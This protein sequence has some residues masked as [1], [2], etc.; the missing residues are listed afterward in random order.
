MEP[1]SGRCC[2]CMNALDCK[3]RSGRC[4]GQTHP[5]V[6][7]QACSMHGGGAA[8]LHTLAAVRY[9][10]PESET[11]THRRTGPLDVHVGVACMREQPAYCQLRDGCQY[12]CGCTALLLDVEENTVLPS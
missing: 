7:V 6:L 4:G 1:P 3:R 10:R 12:S 9:P 8:A 11:T 2:A 5:V